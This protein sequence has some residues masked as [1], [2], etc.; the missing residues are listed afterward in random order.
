MKIINRSTRYNRDVYVIKLEEK[1]VSKSDYDLIK[2]CDGWG[3]AP[4]GGTV[5]RSADGTIEVHVYTD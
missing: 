1:D 5:K 4:F 2:E 3:G